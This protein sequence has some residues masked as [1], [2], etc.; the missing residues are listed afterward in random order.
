MPSLPCFE[1]L[2]PLALLALA[3]CAA[4]SDTTPAGQGGS[5]GQGGAATSAST[6]D[7]ST[8]T[9]ATSTSTGAGPCVTAEDCAGFSDVCNV[10]TC[11]NGACEGVPANEGASCDD[12]KTC[13]TSDTCQAGV[14]TGPLNPCAG[15][16]P[17]H[18]GTCDVETDTCVDMPGNDG[19]SC[20]DDDPCTVTSYCANGAC[21]PGQLTDCSFLD[22]VCGTGTCDP[23][24]GCVAQP[25]N[26]GSACNDGLFCTI[27][28]SCMNGTCQGDPNP[29]VNSPNL[30][31]MV[32]SCNEASDTCTATPG[33]DGQACDDGDACTAGT[34]CSGGSCGG[35]QPANNGVACDDGDPCT[36]N[37]TCSGGSCVGG[38]PVLACTSGDGCC[39]AGC[40]IGADLDCGCFD[41]WLVGSPCN[42]I[43]Y[44]N[45]CSPADTGYH[46]VGLYDG[47]AC[48]WHHKNQAWNT[49]PASNFYNLGVH[50][51]VTPGVGK[52]FWC[53]NKFSAPT[54]LA[55]DTC[56]FYFD[57]N[58]V[59]AWGWC[60]EADPD[61]VGFV[62]IPAEG[63]PGCH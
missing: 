40:D 57:P 6:S 11:I 4:G 41:D 3:A 24:I 13:T 60:A 27:N 15:S 22:S 49:T 20:I 54:P 21:A 18:V 63:H 2:A 23:E 30:D 46:Y 28:D 25:L 19:A 9:A 1:R 5:G 35:G 62:C 47:Y 17:C 29:C 10:G 39:P 14:C 56:P 50:F 42:G 33:N 37:T 59:G 12:G 32:A 8:T 55:Y 38:A 34:T 52:C 61:S 43:D 26:D 51:D 58:N 45:G 44:G 48:F 7:A 36:N 53:A 31:C 16:D